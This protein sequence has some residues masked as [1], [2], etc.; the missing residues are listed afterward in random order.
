MVDVFEEVEE[1]IRADRLKSLGK[2]IVP[3]ALL[4]V[5]IGLLLAGALY[6]WRAYQRSG[7]ETA[8]LAYAQAVEKLAAGDAKGAETQLRTVTEGRSAV[9][10]ALALMQ[11][12]GMRLN[13]GKAPAAAE[14]FEQAAEAAPDPVL[15]DAA[16]LKAVFARMDVQ[17]YAASIEQ[18]TPLAAEDRPYRLLALEALALAR[19]GAGQTQAA[20]A[21]VTAL[22]ITPDA[23]EGL[24]T[25]AQALLQLIDSGAAASL[26]AVAKAAAA[27]PPRPPVAPGAAL[28]PG[29]Q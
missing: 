6:G 19:I 14:L 21:D 28:A 26:P 16:R 22:S 27:L 5:T 29:V 25:R 17:P 8:S 20:R 10:S 24:R 18:L 1:E 2:R 12:G 4:G 7:A 9:Y 13:E 15:E 11:I 23:P 3:W